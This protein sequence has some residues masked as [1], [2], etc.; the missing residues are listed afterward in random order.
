MPSASC[1]AGSSRRA[2]AGI[3]IDVRSSSAIA[4]GTVHTVFAWE[5]TWIARSP[6]NSSATIVR[7]ARARV[8][9]GAPAAHAIAAQPSATTAS[10][11]TRASATTSWVT[12]WRESALATQTASA[13]APA[14]HATAARV[15]QR[16][17][18][19]RRKIAV[20]P[21]PAAAASG[22]I[23]KIRNPAL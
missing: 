22:R 4:P 2:V 11:G 10:P 23:Q 21:A 9:D 19:A 18:S 8:A 15:V 20:R 5:W 7:P 13:I 12:S 1:S 16:R 17:S 14:S 6:A 3:A